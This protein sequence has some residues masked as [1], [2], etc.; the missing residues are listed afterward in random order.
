MLVYLLLGVLIIRIIDKLTESFFHYY[1][2][3]C[4]TYDDLLDAYYINCK[5]VMELQD[6]TPDE[7][8][9]VLT[10]ADGIYEGYEKKMK[11]IKITLN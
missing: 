5:Q 7:K 6:A 1:F 11:G 2:G 9:R 4:K 10:I 3:K 8:M